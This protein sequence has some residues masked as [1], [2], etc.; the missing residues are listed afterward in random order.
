MKRPGKHRFTL[1][2]PE[3]MYE[4]IKLRAEA[5]NIRVTGWIIQT[6]IERLI[7]ERQYH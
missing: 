7:R 3:N 4:E 6:I 5:R 1:D 2:L